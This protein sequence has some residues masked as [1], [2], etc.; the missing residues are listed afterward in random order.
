MADDLQQLAF[1]SEAASAADALSGLLE[2]LEGAQKRNSDS[3]LSGAIAVSGSRY[4]QVL[5]GSP[6]A[7]D[8]TL[9]KI[10]DD[11]RHENV[12]VVARRPIALRSFEAWS[13]ASSTLLPG[14]TPQIDAAIASCETDCDHAI[15]LLRSVV[16]SQQRDGHLLATQQ[17]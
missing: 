8:A 1:R 16:M 9:A 2:I 5:E 14:L 10:E 6:A 17:S 3:S 12:A 15:S 11:P 4:F 13:L 7:I